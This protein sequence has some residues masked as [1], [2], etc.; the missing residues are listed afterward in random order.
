MKFTYK[1]K[2]YEWDL[3]TGFEIEDGSHVQFSGRIYIQKDAPLVVSGGYPRETSFQG[4]ALFFNAL[5]PELSDAER[6]WFFSVQSGVING[7]LA[8]VRTGCLIYSHEGHMTTKPGF[9]NMEDIC[10]SEFSSQDF[11]DIFSRQKRI[12][13]GKRKLR[14]DDIHFADGKTLYDTVNA[15]SGVRCCTRI[16]LAALVY[17][18]GRT[19][20]EIAHEERVKNDTCPTNGTK[21]YAKVPIWGPI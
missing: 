14:I 18:D 10:P 1:D 7:R 5:L 4:E 8:G 15:L 11:T 3:R 2:E 19:L 12:L 6:S 20:A 9:A 13:I 17:K 16:P 21:R